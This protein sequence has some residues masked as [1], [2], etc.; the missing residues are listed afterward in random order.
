MSGFLLSILT[1]Q[2]LQKIS[3]SIANKSLMRFFAVEEASLVGHR[4]VVI[5][6]LRIY[7]HINTFPTS[8]LTSYSFFY[9]KSTLFEPLQ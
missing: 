5:G 1:F 4:C 7:V 2:F 8:V 9:H 3:R 6:I